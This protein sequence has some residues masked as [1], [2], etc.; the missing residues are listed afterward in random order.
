MKFQIQNTTS[1][2]VLGVYEAETVQ[3][4]LDAMARDAGYADY[5]EANAVA[6]AGPLTIM[7]TEFEMGTK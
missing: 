3:E 2:A 4:A 7:V 5:A 6:P 1:G